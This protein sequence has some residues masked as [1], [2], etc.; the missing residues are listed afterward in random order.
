M[1]LDPAAVVLPEPARLAP[2]TVDEELAEIMVVAFLE[3]Y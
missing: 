3:N 1:S 2:D